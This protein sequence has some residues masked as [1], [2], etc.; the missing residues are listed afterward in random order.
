M[1]TSDSDDREIYAERF[2]SR[3]SLMSGTE[4]AGMLKLFQDGKH[5]HGGSVP[6]SNG[7]TPKL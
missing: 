4:R 5:Y 7:V 6:R 3:K 1:A 2:G